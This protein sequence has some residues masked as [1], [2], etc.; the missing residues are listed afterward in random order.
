MIPSDPVTLCL[1][2]AIF[3]EAR[4]EPLEGQ[5]AVAKVIINRVEH[6]RYPDNI[7]GVVW[8][9]YQFSFTHDGLP[10]NPWAY[11]EG[12]DLQSWRQVL[13][14]TEAIL[15]DPEGTLPDLQAT[16]YH[17]DYVYPYWA[18]QFNHEATIGTHIF[19][20]NPDQ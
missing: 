17:A 7:C 20:V 16:Y 18:S 9:P 1:A 12:P 2:L 8:Q 3:Y 19:Y 4:S 11:P 15:E 10:E 14:I 5:L 6:P 13:L